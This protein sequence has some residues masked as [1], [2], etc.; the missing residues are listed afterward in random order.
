MDAR[1]Y[2]DA[3]AQDPAQRLKDFQTKVA[4]VYVT[5]KDL[6]VGCFLTRVRSRQA[7]GELQQHAAVLSLAHNFAWITNGARSFINTATE[8]D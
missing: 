6:P 7:L 5:A 3:F 2:V 4:H 8:G 1:N